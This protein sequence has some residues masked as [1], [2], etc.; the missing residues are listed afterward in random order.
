MMAL[1]STIFSKD[2]RVLSWSHQCCPVLWYSCVLSWLDGHEEVLQNA[3][4]P[5]C[6]DQKSSK[7]EAAAFTGKLEYKKYPKAVWNSMSKEQ[8]M[9]VRKLREQ[10]GIKPTV[11]QFMAKARITALRLSLGLILNP[12]RRILRRK[13]DLTVT[14]QALG[15]KC[16]KP[17]SLLGS[18]KGKVNMS[19][20]KKLL[21]LVPVCKKCS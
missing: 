21:H 19:C 14:C 17:S 20:V 2:S 4:C 7:P 9:Q 13:R 5:Y 1:K 15:G 6:Q 10:Q 18:L 8:Q 16:K 12:R 3:I 11:R